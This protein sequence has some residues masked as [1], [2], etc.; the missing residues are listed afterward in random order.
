M[1]IISFIEEQAVI[2]QILHHL[3]LWEVRNNGPPQVPL[4]NMVREPTYQPVRDHAPAG[5]DVRNPHP[6]D[7]IELF[8][9]SRFFC[10]VEY[11]EGLS[12]SFCLSENVLPNP[13]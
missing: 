8:Q 11:P 9:K 12:R 1:K 7:T 13:A 3:G 2:K 5:D 4:L 10:N 6:G